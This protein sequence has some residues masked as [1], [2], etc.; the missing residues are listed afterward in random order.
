V[1]NLG[2]GNF[3]LY[4]F[5]LFFGI[6]QLILSFISPDLIVKNRPI[7]QPSVFPMNWGF[8]GQFYQTNGL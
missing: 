1:V 6:C 4:K 2:I 8:S 7:S 3:G 5:S